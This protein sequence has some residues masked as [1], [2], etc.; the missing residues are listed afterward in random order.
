MLSLIG[1]LT[2]LCVEC[3]ALTH[4]QQHGNIMFS[5]T[6]KVRQNHKP[7]YEIRPTLKK[8]VWLSRNAF[9]RQLPQHPHLQMKLRLLF[10]N[11]DIGWQTLTVVD[12]W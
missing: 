3:K 5:F 8:V 11:K 4:L 7:N 1:A 6:I 9:A 10:P 12:V 2:R